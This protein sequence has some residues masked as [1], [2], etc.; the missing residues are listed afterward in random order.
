[1]LVPWQSQCLGKL[2]P[3]KQSIHLSI[4]L[5]PQN[6]LP[7]CPPLWSPAS[8]ANR[9]RSKP[10]GVDR[11]LQC[12]SLTAEA[13]DTAHNWAQEIKLGPKTHDSLHEFLE[14]FP[15]NVAVSWLIGHSP[16]CYPCA[17]Y[18]Y[19]IVEV[20]SF[21]SRHFPSWVSVLSIALWRIAST[22]HFFG[23][24][25]VMSLTLKIWLDSCW[26]AWMVVLQRVPSLEPSAEAIVRLAACDP[27]IYV[28]RV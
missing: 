3:C 19:R 23:L 26:A 9:C 25:T 6:C 18:M 20:P 4:H 27:Q 16:V 11:H 2:R 13:L 10:C 17:L 28:D 8:Q 7:T 21:S 12:Q 1:M 15:F 22:M 14:T 5:R 24:R